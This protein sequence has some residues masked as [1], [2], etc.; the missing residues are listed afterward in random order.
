MAK[1]L[2]PALL[3]AGWAQAAEFPAKRWPGW[4]GP[5]AN[6]TAPS[7]RYAVKFS[8]DEN[9]AW[10]VKLPA[11]GCSTP[12]VW[13]EQIFVTTPRQGKDALLA[14][15]WAGKKRWQATFGRE[16]RGKN[17]N[18]SGSNPSPVTDGKRVF[19]HFKSGTLAG[20]DM[21]GKELW[22][23]NVIE[24]FGPIK[25]YWDH[26]TSPVLTKNDVVQAVM[27][28][29]SSYL[30]AF[31]QK[32]GEMS[33]KVDRHYNLRR[34]G[35]ESYASPIVTTQGGKEVIIV[36]GGEH[37][38]A[39]D[40]KDGSIVWSCGGFNPNKKGNWVHVASPVLSGDM[41]IV[42]FGRG[43][44]ETLTGIK[45]NGSG[46]VTRTHIR[47]KRTD[48]GTFVTTPVAHNGKV[49]IVEGVQNRR[50][51]RVICLDPATGKTVWEGEL[52]KGGGEF[53]S[54]PVIADG[55]LYVARIDGTVFVAQIDGGFKVLAQN[56]MGE[57]II[58]APVPV[59]NHI[60]IRGERHLFCVAPPR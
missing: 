10:K 51:G 46:D 28:Q 34:E 20:L 27:N 49:Y 16:N 2:I 59:A 17:R 52:Q 22:Q 7:G 21:S 45:L 29:R 14:F 31:N 43:G 5:N 38:D 58:A 56:R 60:L 39:H 54:S 24:R 15:D 36:W 32:T 25:L 53:Y 48:R 57:K 11:K 9:L 30:V 8:A 19:V 23:T 40:A 42:P 47:W 26:A 37:L 4:R 13:G 55:K 35:D 33:W 3:L 50:H 1:I 12:A 18:G 41:A 6:G 44:G